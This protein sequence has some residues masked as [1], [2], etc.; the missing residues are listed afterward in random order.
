MVLTP[1]TLIVDTFQDPL[2]QQVW[3]LLMSVALSWLK[4]PPLA[5]TEEVTR[6]VPHGGTAVW[7]LLIYRTS[8]EMAAGASNANHAWHAG[9]SLQR[10][11]ERERGR[12]QETVYSSYM[13]K[14]TSCS[15]YFAVKSRIKFPSLKEP[16]K[17]ICWSSGC[18]TAIN[19]HQALRQSVR[20]DSHY[21]GYA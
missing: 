21:T 17:C 16:D 20:M 8:S 2:P 5:S 7:F 11:R 4:V 15:T 10:E 1:V 18:W 3:S 9:P 19:H 6:T 12:E 13:T 14:M